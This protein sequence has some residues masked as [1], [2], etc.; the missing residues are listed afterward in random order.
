MQGK[1]ESNQRT[2]FSVSMEL[3]PCT[4]R[5]FANAKPGCIPPCGL[6]NSLLP[7][8]ASIRITVNLFILQISDLITSSGMSSCVRMTSTRTFIFTWN[9]QNEWSALNEFFKFSELDG[10]SA[11]DLRRRYMCVFIFVN[12]GPGNPSLFVIEWPI[13]I[14][15]WNNH[16]NHYPVRPNSKH[17]TDWW[18]KPRCYFSPGRQNKRR[19][20]HR[21][22]LLQANGQVNSFYK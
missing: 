10:R 5:R 2:L 4:W 7:F 11:L 6:K 17:R 16:F 21:W 1:R 20:L 3:L 19:R 8:K 18:T 13:R 15:T 12:T 22:W 14:Y 9:L